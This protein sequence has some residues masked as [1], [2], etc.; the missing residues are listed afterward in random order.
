MKEFQNEN[1][2]IVFFIQEHEGFLRKNSNLRVLRDE[3]T[4]G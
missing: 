4:S 3:I 1:S 2:I